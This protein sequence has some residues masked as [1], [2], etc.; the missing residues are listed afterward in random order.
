MN[1][2]SASPNENM[3][4][5]SSINPMPA[6]RAERSSEVESFANRLISDAAL[7]LCRA[8]VMAASRSPSPI[9]VFG[10]ARFKDVDARDKPGH[11]E[12]MSALP[13][14]PRCDTGMSAAKQSRKPP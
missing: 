10:A 2:P 9:H 5:A 7:H 1:F 8:A 14:P 13:Q 12:L 11:D 6:S 3:K 4:I